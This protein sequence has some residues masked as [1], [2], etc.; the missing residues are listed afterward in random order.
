MAIGVGGKDGSRALRQAG[1]GLV[2]GDCSRPIVDVRE[3]GARARQRD[4]VGGFAK[5]MGRSDNLV[6]R[7]DPESLQD[8]QKRDFAA[9]DGDCMLAAE[10]MRE[11]RLECLDDGSRRE[12]G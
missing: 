5:G 2:R 6:A 9:G 4:G 7:A 12:P 11:R 8:E 10:I 3:D 1:S